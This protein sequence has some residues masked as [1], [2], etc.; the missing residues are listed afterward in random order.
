MA[1]YTPIIKNIREQ[2]G[3]L[4]FTISNINVSLANSL[5]RI[6]L[7][8]IPCVVFR[9][10]P[11]NENKA[12]IEIN[13]TRINNEIIKQRLSCIPIHINDPNF[14]IHNFC[15]EID[16]KNTSNTIQYVTT[17]DIKIKDK[18][19]NKYISEKE[20]RE[21][22][23]PN[24]ITKYYIDIARLR[25]KLNENMDGEHLKLSCDF[26]I[27]T[28]KEDGA[29]NVVSTATYSYTPDEEKLKNEHKIFIEKLKQ[30]GKSKEEIEFESKDWLILNKQRHYIENSFDFVIESVG[31]FTNYEIIYKSIDIMIQK[32][33]K[34]KDDITNNDNINRLITDSNVTILYS[35]DILLE[36]EDYTL[37]KALEYML[38]RE[39]F[40]TKRLTFCGF[41]KPHP[42]INNSIIR[43][44][45]PDKKDDPTSF[46]INYMTDSINK[47]IEIY[48]NIEKV[49][50]SK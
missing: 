24:P 46:I 17:E 21:I 40:N 45:F 2:D 5:R 8:E 31:Q 26:S 3:N 6:M 16:K 44:A 19:K 41:Y 22:F 42:H 47:L 12:N 25:P 15:I 9:T 11:H 10:F 48:T 27:G 14:P 4:H 20:V 7:A 34:F 35:Y 49:F 37:G 32:L 13:T 43:I 18:E 33:N 23:P 30:A 50:M 36:N 28:A 39:Y 1:N 38:Y 29:F